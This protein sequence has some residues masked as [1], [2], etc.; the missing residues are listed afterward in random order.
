MKKTAPSIHEL[1]AFDAVAHHQSM[2]AAANALCITISG[3]S[4]QI[5]KLEEYI[6]TPLLIKKGR[7]IELSATGKKY[8][9]K[10]APSLRAIEVATIEAMST[11]DDS[12]IITLACVPTFLTFWLIPKLPSFRKQYPNI[13]FNFD[14][15][16]SPTS[17]SLSLSIDA[18][19]R[20]G[21]GDWHNIISDYITGREFICVYSKKNLSNDKEIKTPQ[22]LI[23][24]ALLHHEESTNVWNKW[25]SQHNLQ[26][27]NILLG[28]KF[29]QYSAIIPAIRNGLGVGL[30]PR[31]FVEEEIQKGELQ[32]FGQPVDVEQ[33]HYLCFDLNAL[34]KPA[35]VIFRQWIL[36]EGQRDESLT[37]SEKTNSRNPSA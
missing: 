6:G 14:Q 25:A 17:H 1:Q 9:S 31:I 19:I 21:T 13:T 8:W 18:A 20:Y 7:G 2:T 5:S 36:H 12:G 34:E 24:Y 22:E 10:I 4:K 30:V 23:N 37:K 26:E 32:V 28:L 11:D 16:L 33:S 27:I 35:F 15:H 29:V 3:I